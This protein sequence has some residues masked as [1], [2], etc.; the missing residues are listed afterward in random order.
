MTVLTYSLLWLPCAIVHFTAAQSGIFEVDLI[1]PRNGTWSPANITPIVFAVQQPQ[2]SA[3]V[4]RRV[5]QWTLGQYGN[6]SD[7]AI[8]SGQISFEASGSSPNLYLAA[9]YTNA[10]AG[11]ED[12]W[13]FRW[14]FS[15]R[16]CS[17]ITSENA[18][19]S[20]TSSSQ[21]RSV[22]FRTSK[23]APAL[24]I[25]T[26]L[27][28]QSCRDTRYVAYNVTAIQS[29]PT[30]DINSPVPSSCVVLG[31]PP[32]VTGNPCAVT[33]DAAA[34][35]SASAAISYAACQATATSCTSPSAT[36]KPSSGHRL[37]GGRP[38][39]WAFMGVLGVACL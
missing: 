35:S 4:Q 37:T 22:G 6:P 21:G 28:L 3:L 7:L 5:I 11:I 23:S 27:S 24:N 17:L 20:Y 15:T 26:A 2:L 16:N 29:P 12:D 38:Y 34:S 39:V 19:S 10:T 18:L 30:A 8:H 1:S 14:Q 36:T 32:M 13:V 31:S 25:D 33:I 9:G